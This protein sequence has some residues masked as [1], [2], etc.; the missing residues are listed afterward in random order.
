MKLGSITR[1]S[2]HTL[3]YPDVSTSEYV[4]AAMTTARGRT[5]C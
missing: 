1:V 4:W 5:Y 2:T 3:L